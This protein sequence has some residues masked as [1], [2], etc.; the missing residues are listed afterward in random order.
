MKNIPV[1]YKLASYKYDLP[2]HCIA[3]MPV[4]KRADSR[5]LVLEAE[6]DSCR[7]GHFADIVNYPEPGDLVIINDTKV[8]PARLTGEKK[9]GGKLE[10]FILEYPGSVEKITEPSIGF[11]K[12]WKQVELIG[13]LKC[14]RRPAAG[15]EF[16]F[17][18]E[19]KG[20]VKEYLENGQVKVTLSYLGD[21]EQQLEQNGNIPLPPYIHRDEKLHFDRQRYQTVFASQTGA[22]AAPTAGLHFT[23]EILDELSRKGVKIARVTLHVGYGTF[24]PIRTDDIRKHDI[25]QEYYKL[26]GDSAGMINEAKAQGKKIWA[27]GTTSVRVLESVVNDQGLV[28]PGQGWCKLYIYPGFEFKVID[29]LITNFHLPGSSLL[30]LVSALVGRNRILD[31]YQTAVESGYRFFSYGDAMMIIGKK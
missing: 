21:F 5:L 6:N 10:F 20:C 15:V 11:E 19:L 1:D 4:E 30:F 9:T 31:S 18:P 22:V 8:F 28:E 26:S 3:Q 12:A 25:H 14:S 29:N 16:F 7:H 17:S 23:R 2:E 24:A 27:V 13:L